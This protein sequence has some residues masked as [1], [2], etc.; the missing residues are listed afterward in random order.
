LSEPARART[1]V[2]KGCVLHV[3]EG[4]DGAWRWSVMTPAGGFMCNV[5]ENGTEDD[6][7]DEALTC[8]LGWALGETERLRA[9]EL[10]E[11]RAESDRANRVRYWRG[12][13]KAHL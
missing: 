11:A 5:S 13:L 4:P 8:A 10:Q 3:W 2:L 7:R 1:K 12:R 9:V 6:A